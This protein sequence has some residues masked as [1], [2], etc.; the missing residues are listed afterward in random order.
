VRVRHWGLRV[1]VLEEEDV[2]GEGPVVHALGD[3]LHDDAVPEAPVVV[4]AVLMTQLLGR[5]QHWGFST[6]KYSVVYSE[7]RVSL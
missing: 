2:D 5:T 3:A 6:D 7:V 1:R 4:G